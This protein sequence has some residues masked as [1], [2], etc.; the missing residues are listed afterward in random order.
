MGGWERT[1]VTTEEGVPAELGGVIPVVIKAGPLAIRAMFKILELMPRP[2]SSLFRMTNSFVP[3]PQRTRWPFRR[4]LS[5]GN[6]P[7]DDDDSLTCCLV[8]R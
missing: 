4:R 8:D 6:I 1:G 5:F 7:D 3:E 2:S